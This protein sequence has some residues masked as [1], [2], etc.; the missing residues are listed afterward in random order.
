MATRKGDPKGPRK[1]APIKKEK[2][3]REDPV[4]ETGSSVRKHKHCVNCGLS[5]DP[6]EEYCSDACKSSFEKMVKKKKQMMWLPYI[7][8][9][10]LILF[11]ILIMA[12]Q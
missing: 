4:P 11:Y 7:G 9:A 10:L 6:A 8:I 1:K 2:K 12:N 5:V 3:N